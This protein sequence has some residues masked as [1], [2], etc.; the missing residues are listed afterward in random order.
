M[1]CF[2]KSGKSNPSL[3]ERIDEELQKIDVPPRRTA[4]DEAGREA[5]RAK[6][7]RVNL[8]FRRSI[9]IPDPTQTWT[10]RGKAP[11][12]VNVVGREACLIPVEG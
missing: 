1:I 4:G 3:L 12:W 2:S 6:K 8:H 5:G 7:K 9:A 10:G 11:A